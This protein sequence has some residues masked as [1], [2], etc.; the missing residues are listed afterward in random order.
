MLMFFEFIL[1]FTI[2]MLLFIN[3]L[4]FNNQNLT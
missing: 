3:T 2:A 1:H 4:L